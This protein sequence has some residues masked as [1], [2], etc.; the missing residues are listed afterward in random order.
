MRSLFIIRLKILYCVGRRCANFLYINNKQQAGVRSATPAGRQ[1]KINIKIPCNAGNMCERLPCN[2]KSTFILFLSRIR[3]NYKYYRSAQESDKIKNQTIN[4]IGC[5][6]GVFIWIL[7]GI[8]L[9]VR[10]S[11]KSIQ[12]AW[13]RINWS[14]PSEIIPGI[15]SLEEKNIKRAGPAF[16]LADK[17]YNKKSQFE[18]WLVGVTDGDG[19]FHFSE[20]SPR[21][22]VLHFKIAQSTYN[23]R[24][25]HYIK[26]NLGVG[27]VTVAADGMAE[28]RLR[29]VKKIIQYIIPIFDKY[30][31]LTSKYYNYDLFKK[32]AFIL[33]DPSLSK[34]KKQDLLTELKLASK[35]RPENYISPVWNYNVTHP[36]LGSGT[37]QLIGANNRNMC[38]QQKKGSEKLAACALAVTG[39]VE[40]GPGTLNNFSFSLRRE[41]AI[42]IISKAWLIGFTEA[43]GS[44]YLVT[45]SE[46][47][48]CHGFEITQKLD[49]IVL[50][51]IGLIL[52]IKV[53]NKKTYYSVGTTN[54]KHVSNIISYYEDTMAGMKSLEYRIW[55]R[56]FKKFYQPYPLISNRNSALSLGSGKEKFNYLTKVRDQMR[57][58][59]SIRLDKNF[60]IINKYN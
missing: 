14:K 17:T 2:H 6:Q 4:L 46:G 47:R 58:I 44:F 9:M 33:N 5:C 45:K 54:S 8:L 19:T 20:Y 18:P 57:K 1:K 16:F 22:W 15:F 12:S 51:G 53:Y 59:R 37:L 3:L 32:A 49:K 55:A 13:L 11:K 42:K 36:H 24:L 56:S 26:S 25:L 7:W 30:P 29:D 27:Q 21:K 31:L 38:F 43:E 10:M 35:E 48:I 40:E 41:N 23:F 34:D 39:K 28:Y 52:N 60:N 50:E